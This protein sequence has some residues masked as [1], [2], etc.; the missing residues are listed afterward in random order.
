MPDA[1]IL[2]PFLDGLPEAV[3]TVTSGHQTHFWNR[4]AE[5]RGIVILGPSQVAEYL[6]AT[7]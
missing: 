6:E 3:A 7:R 1:P 5:T 2:S 4:A